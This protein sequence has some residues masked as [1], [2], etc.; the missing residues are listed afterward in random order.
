MSFILVI[1]ELRGMAIQLIAGDGRRVSSDSYFPVWRTETP[2]G[3][4]RSEWMDDGVLH[5]DKR[6][7]PRLLQELSVFSRISQCRLIT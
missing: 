3:L 7:A 6:E 1:E 4:K 5:D 2:I